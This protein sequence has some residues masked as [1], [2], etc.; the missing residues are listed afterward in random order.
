MTDSNPYDGDYK[1]PTSLFDELYDQ[2]KLAKLAYTMGYIFDAS[3]EAKKQG[4]EFYGINVD[5]DS[6]DRKQFTHAVADAE[7]FRSFT[8]GE[9]KEVMEKNADFM[10]KFKPGSFSSEKLEGHYSFLEKLQAESDASGIERALALEE[11]DDAFQDKECVYGVTRDSV[12]KRITVVFR[13]TLTGYSEYT[14]KVSVSNWFS[15]LAIKKK[16]VEVPAILKKSEGS[17][18]LAFHTGF[19]GKYASFLQLLKS[20]HNILTLSFIRLPLQRD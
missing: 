4:V 3:R 11:F 15:N 7:L 8:P 6:D 18:V 9:I 12:N 20:S 16:K 2:G 14:F 19:Y 5:S 13:G 10:N 1:W 17:E